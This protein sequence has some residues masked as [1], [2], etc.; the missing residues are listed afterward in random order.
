MTST[1]QGREGSETRSGRITPLRALFALAVLIG[2]LFGGLAFGSA[3]GASPAPHAAATAP[4]GPASPSAP[5][6]PEGPTTSGGVSVNVGGKPSQSISILMLVTVLSVAP[7]LL[8]LVTSFTKIFVVL[9]LTRNA[10]GLTTVPPNQVL[11][12]LSLFL[13]LFVMGPV[14]SKVNS[15]GI[16]PYLHGTKN[17]AQAWT[18]GT[19]PLRHFMLQ[20]TRPQ[21]IALMLR[22]GNL[23]N[24]ADKSHIELTTLIPA[25]VL[26]ELRSAMIIGFVVFVPFVIID[27]VVSSSLMSLGMM[28]LPP[29]S[30]SLPFKL[31]L[32]VLVDGWGLIITALVR[33]YRGGG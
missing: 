25:F 15:L 30:I 4:A 14:L 24:P 27:L 1:V 33:S 22:A 32:F 16:Q 3:A 31:L 17:R 21:E 28:M 10:L 8:L 20:H 29:V 12:G 7:S 23:P 9:S 19:E 11:A 13:S 6:G 26:S 18:D 2:C 5:S